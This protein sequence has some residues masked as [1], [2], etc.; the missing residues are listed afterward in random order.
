MPSPDHYDEKENRVLALMAT[1]PSACAQNTARAVRILDF[2]SNNKLTVTDLN[3]IIS[4][5]DHL[6]VGEKSRL[7]GL[8]RKHSQLFD[9]KLGDWNTTPASLEL[10]PDAVPFHGAAYPVPHIHKAEVRAELDR[11]LSL[12]II[13]RCDESQWGSPT[14][15]IPKKHNKGV[16]MVTDFRRLNKMLIRKPYPIPKIS[17]V[18]QELEGL[19]WATALDLTMGY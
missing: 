7:G 8:L 18:L 12:G 16:R 4:S 6:S 9:G 11:L 1:E 17:E 15:F 13:E 10:K 2:S 14:F 3:E 19:Q 5:Y